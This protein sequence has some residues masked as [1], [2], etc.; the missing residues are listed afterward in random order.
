MHGVLCVSEN[1]HAHMYA[2]STTTSVMIR[3]KLC[4]VNFLLNVLGLQLRLSA[5]YDKHL[6]LL[7]KLA[8][9]LPKNEYIYIF[10]ILHCSLEKQHVN[11]PHISG[12]FH[13]RHVS[14]HQCLQTRMQVVASALMVLC[15]S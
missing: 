2:Y 10:S 15:H 6:Y 5:F 3:G 8:G 4:G 11:F 12:L 1:M 9:C 7:S 14:Q 13:S